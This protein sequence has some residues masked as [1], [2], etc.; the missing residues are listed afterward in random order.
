[1][2]V[3]DQTGYTVRFNYPPKRIISLVP[4]QTE[5]LMDLGLEEEIAGITKFCIH[6][7]KVFRSKPRVGGTK[8]INMSRIKAL[9]PDLI[10]ANKEENEKEQIL[11]LRKHYPVWTSEIYDLEGSIDMILRIGEITAAR[12]KSIKIVSQITEEFNKLETYCTALKPLRTVYLI[13][14]KPWMA[15]GKQTFIN[16]L[17]KLCNYQNIL[18]DYDSRYPSFQLEELENLNPE[19][20]ILSSEP[21]PFKEKHLAEISE[22]YPHAK[23]LLADGELFSWYGSRL[24][25]A[26]EYLQ[27][28]RKIADH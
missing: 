18:L 24:L 16:H 7:E 6:P 10:I 5:L 28:L 23:V 3:I 11:E 12:E 4:S 26:P 9:D 17:L 25:K 13:W 1:M 27:H 8:T 14:R 21:Y 22:V 2:E 20:F 15:A 19:L